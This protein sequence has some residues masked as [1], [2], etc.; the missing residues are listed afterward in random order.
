MNSDEGALMSS[1]RWMCVLGISLLSAACAPETLEGFEP[2]PP[3]NM[4]NP[5]NNS[6]TNMN[7]TNNM[8]GAFTT[9]FVNV[10]SILT[11]NCT[12]AAC[13][14]QFSA[15]GFVVATD[16]NA[17]PAEMR[18][19]LVGKRANVSG[20]LLIDPGNLATSDIWTRMRLP[21]T[22][23]AYMPSTK[24]VLDTA[25]YSALESWITNGAIYTE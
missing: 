10:T 18:G 15:N 6:S 2:A 3:N 8:G 5:P 7:N 21:T 17:T 1:V 22:D 24:Q 13:H 19:A 4:N 25:A 16:Q 12:Q 9:E 20:D 23:T 14:G 11:A